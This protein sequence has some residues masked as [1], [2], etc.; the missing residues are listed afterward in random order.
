MEVTKVNTYGLVFKLEGS[1]SSLKPLLLMGHQDV[2]PVNRETVSEWVHPPFS[3]HFDGK[4]EENI[5]R[6]A[7]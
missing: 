3:G 5:N 2:V 7:L 4:L 1:D 6:T